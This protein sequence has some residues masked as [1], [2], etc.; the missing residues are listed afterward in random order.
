MATVG[1]RVLWPT[2]R[3]DT[4]VAASPCSSRVLYSRLRPERH[5]SSPLASSPL[6]RC[7]RVIQI[8]RRRPRVLHLHISHLVPQAHVVLLGYPRWS[9]AILIHIILEALEG[10][11]A[12]RI[13]L[14]VRVCLCLRD[15]ARDVDCQR[16]EMEVDDVLVVAGP[17]LIP[18]MNAI[19]HGDKLVNEANNLR[20]INLPINIVAIPRC[21]SGIVSPG[22]ESVVSSAALEGFLALT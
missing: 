2:S 17:L 19:R 8:R 4:P 20:P 12:L 21:S 9:R 13:Y 10:C 22:P 11:C 1:G 5:H 6:A 15:E 16:L 3:Y 14:P 18:R 7:S